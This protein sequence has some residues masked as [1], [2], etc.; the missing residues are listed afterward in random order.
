LPVTWQNDHRDEELPPAKNFAVVGEPPDRLKAAF[1][2]ER[3]TGRESKRGSAKRS[4]SSTKKA[5][6]A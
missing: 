4:T 5:S 2:R 3:Q 1:A 6:K